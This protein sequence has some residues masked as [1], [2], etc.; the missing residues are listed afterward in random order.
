MTVWAEAFRS[1]KEEEYRTEAL[2]LAEE[3]KNLYPDTEKW[4]DFLN[5]GKEFPGLQY[6]Y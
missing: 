1:L 5:T 6:W 3:L 2:R 4:I